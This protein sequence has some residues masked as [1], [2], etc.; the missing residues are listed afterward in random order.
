M[1]SL[2][3][4]VPIRR[5]ALAPSGP[6]ESRHRQSQRLSWSSALAPCVVW[7][8]VD[9]FFGCE[10]SAWQLSQLDSLHPVPIDT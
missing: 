7:S 6:D 1:K 10:P 8:N 3:G 5:R 9:V 2:S 4:P